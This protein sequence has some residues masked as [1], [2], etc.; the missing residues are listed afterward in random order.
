MEDVILTDAEIAAQNEVIAAENAVI[1]AENAI[2]AK[3]I[4]DALNAVPVVVDET[5]TDTP[6][7]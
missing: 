6:V 1:A 3:E 7:V 5:P 2:K 4:S